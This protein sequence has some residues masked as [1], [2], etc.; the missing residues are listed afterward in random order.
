MTDPSAGSEP[1]AMAAMSQA[2]SG[3][4][5]DSSPWR[6]SMPPATDRATQTL[7]SLLAG[8]LGPVGMT[9]Q[10]HRHPRGLRRQQVLADGWR[11]AGCRRRRRGPTDRGSRRRS[12]RGRTG[13]V[14]ESGSAAARRLDRADRHS[15]PPM[16]PMGA[17]AGVPV[18]SRRGSTSGQRHGHA[19]GGGRAGRAVADPGDQQRVLARAEPVA[20]HA[21]GAAALARVLGQRGHL[22]RARLRA[23][24]RGG[25]AGH[26]HDERA[27]RS[28]GR[29]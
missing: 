4:R 2:A 12:R 3:V 19:R 17:A 25:R 10:Q 26:R 6:S 5:S 1:A 18:P 29:R 8:P 20:A 9:G 22:D 16:P 11:A 13:A 15:A 23:G 24:Q 14:P 28:G 7:S 21:A 27:R